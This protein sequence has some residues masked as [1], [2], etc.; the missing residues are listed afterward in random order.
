MSPSSRVKSV[1]LLSGGLDSSANLAFCREYDD[2]VLALTVRYGQRSQ[3]RE[4]AAAKKF[5]EVYQVA[6]QVLDLPWLGSLGGSALTSNAN[7]VPSLTTDQLDDRIVTEQSAKSVWVPNRNGILINAAAAFAERLGAERVVVGFNSEEA[8]TFP[9]NSEEFIK[10]A[11]RSLEYSTSNQVRVFCY[12]T[13]KNKKQIVNELAHLSKP[14]PFEHVWSCYH[15]G[16]KVCGECESCRR[17]ARALA[18]APGRLV[19]GKLREKIDG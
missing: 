1:V 9:D 18:H 15:G 5:C 7:E 4:V 17:L 10:R 12:T 3:D 8:V 11:T 13:D 16:E 2:P 14:F 19:T 6:H